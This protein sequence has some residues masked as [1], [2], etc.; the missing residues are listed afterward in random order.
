MAERTDET[1][2]LPNLQMEDKFVIQGKQYTVS[3]EDDQLHW[4]PVSKGKAG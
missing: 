3:L 1:S 2:V 4:T